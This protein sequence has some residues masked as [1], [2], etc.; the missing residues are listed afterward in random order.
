MKKTRTTPIE[1]DKAE[2]QQIGHQLIDLVA[3]FL[4]TIGE[5]P[6]TSGET[7]RQIHAVLGNAQL[8]ERGSSAAELFEKTIDLVFNHSLLNGHPKFLGYITASPAP[9][10]VLADLLAT[11]VNA[12]VGANVLSPMATAIEKQTVKWL[13]EFIGLSPSYGGILVSGGNVANFTAFL[14]AR[15]AKAPVSLKTGGLRSLPQQLVAVLLGN[16]TYLD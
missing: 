5:K 3:D 2:F 15:T 9:I 10:G 8:P 6:V 11:A 12:N 4:A 16:Y 7:P 1:L 13:A 14:A